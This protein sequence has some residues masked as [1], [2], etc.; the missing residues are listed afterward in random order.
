MHTMKEE[1]VAVIEKLPD[2]VDIDEIIKEL[3]GLKT[4]QDDTDGPENRQ[5]SCLDIAKKYIGCVEG[6]ADLSTN[7]KYFEGFGR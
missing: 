3:A 7:K 2:T 4:T 6:P 5:I 1:A